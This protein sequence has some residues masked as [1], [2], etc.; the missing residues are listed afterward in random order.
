MRKTKPIERVARV[1]LRFRR[2]RT[3]NSH[4]DFHTA[5]V[6]SADPTREDRVHVTAAGAGSEDSRRQ[7]EA[8]LEIARRLAKL[9]DVEI[10]EIGRMR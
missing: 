8:A 6:I 4:H 7:R 10:Q 3:K 2:P 5:A 9:Y 1:T